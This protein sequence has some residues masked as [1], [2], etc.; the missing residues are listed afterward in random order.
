M[1]KK[2]ISFF[3]AVMVLFASLSAY[4]DGEGAEP[5]EPAVPEVS[6]VNETRT[7]TVSADTIQ[8][9][10]TV[11]SICVYLPGY[12]A[13]SFNGT[14]LEAISAYIGEA[15]VSSDKKINKVF[16]LSEEAP[17]GRYTVNIFVPG[18]STPSSYSFDY[19]NITRA[20]NVLLTAQTKTKEE[21]RTSLDKGIN[22]VLVEAAVEYLQYDD[23]KRDYVAAN[24]E[25]SR[26]ADMTAFQT[27]L[28]AE[29]NKINKTEALS[30]MD[31]TNVKKTLEEDPALYMVDGFMTDY[32]ALSDTRKEILYSELSKTI[33]DCVFPEDVKTVFSDALATAK[34]YVEQ[35]VISKPG[36]SS[37]S[38][39]G[40][41]G[42]F[43]GT[44]TNIYA[45]TLLPEPEQTP[46]PEEQ[47]FDD[48]ADFDW[49]KNA[50]NILASNKIINGREENKFFPSDLVTRAEFLKMT[51]GGFY[52][53]PASV[54][55]LPFSDVVYGEWYYDSVM[56]AYQYNIVKGISDTEF[57]TNDNITRQDIAVILYNTLTSTGKSFDNYDEKEEFSDS[58]EIADYAKKAVEALQK[59]DIING[60]DSNEFAPKEPATRAEAAKMLYQTMYE[61]NMF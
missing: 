41:G 40:G 24:I 19:R 14:N 53:K 6:V 7:V 31:R 11:A 51:V 37:S 33:A 46:A 26:P 1:T 16:K 27:Q 5:S 61:F 23:D 10:G 29:I 28:L 9:A 36:I 55:T 39:G 52:I 44:K 34:A 8:Y 2:F 35:T 47:Y 58:G 48:L 22:D 45:E 38:G 50:V 13:A 59:A 42:G 17:S 57:G 49:A 4:A 30:K 18:L 15:V 60:R 32:T 25:S 20:E 3:A 12:S 43:G 21:I 54:S 56:A